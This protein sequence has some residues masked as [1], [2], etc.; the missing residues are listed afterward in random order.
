[1]NLG[2]QQYLEQL[3]RSRYLMEQQRQEFIDRLTERWRIRMQ[4]Q[5][6]LQLI[7]Q[8]TPN[9]RFS[10]RSGVTYVPGSVPV[11]YNMLTPYSTQ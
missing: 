2:N 10:P 8:I 11:D 3:S 6:N 9:Y 7:N 4:N 5:M 1:M